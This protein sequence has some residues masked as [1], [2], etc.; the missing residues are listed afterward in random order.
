MLGEVAILNKFPVPP[1]KGYRRGDLPW[2]LMA[3]LA[4]TFLAVP[5][6]LAY[7]TIAELPPA[8]GLYAAALPT[9]IGSFFRSS[10]HV[11]AGPT[12]ALSLLVGGAVIAGVAGADPVEMAMLLALMV[13]LFQIGAGALRLGAIVDYI[14]APVVLGYITGAGVLIGIGQLYNLVGTAGPRGRIWVTIGGWIETLGQTSSTSLAVGLGTTAVVIA[15]RFINRKIPGAIVAITLAI[16]VNLIF[17]L[18]KMG[19]KVVSDIAAIPRGFPPFH[20]P[21][22]NGFVDLIP[23]AVACTVLSLIES[24]AVA[25]SIA[26]RT[27]QRLDSSTEFVGQGL[28]NVAAGLFGGYPVSGSLSR[29]ALN[30]KAGGKTR[31]AGVIAG[32]FMV[33]ALL[34]LGP[35]LNHTP[36]ASLAGLLLVV[37]WDLVDREKIKKTLRASWPDRTAFVATVLGTWAMSLDKAIYLG[38]GIS[39]V[40]FLR[41]AR[42]LT[43]RELVVDEGGRLREVQIGAPLKEGHKR[44]DHLR[45]LHLEGALFFGAAGELQNALD[46][47]T[48]DDAVR[49]LIVRMKRTQGLD[50]SIAGIFEGAAQTLAQQ[51]RSL[52]LVGISDDARAVLDGYQASQSIGEEN[53]FKV[54]P[55]WF[56]ELSTALKQANDKLTDDGYPPCTLALPNGYAA[57][58][59]DPGDQT[60]L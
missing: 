58:T 23:V 52:M 10:S 47:M 33:V 28:S 19:L 40:L 42:L 55:T 15:T 11:V 32:L 3:A 9:I 18:E 16:A 29:S 4:V 13:G 46:E 8:V 21:S 7:A 34:A 48:R 50:A 17:G 41:K 39:L 6:G 49:V 24:N 37:A 27:G 26:A 30:E 2:D 51:G 36:M 31:M 35:L 53:L 5:Q 43:A 59:P 38:V 25:R 54:K 56:D 44:C 60:D 22:F 14:S 1:L 20:L 57:G 45:L 12:N